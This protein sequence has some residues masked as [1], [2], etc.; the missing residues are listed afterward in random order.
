MPENYPSSMKTHSSF[1]AKN[2]IKIIT[3]IR[4]TDIRLALQAFLEMLHL[5]SV[6]HFCCYKFKIFQA[7]ADD[8]I[9]DLTLNTRS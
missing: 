4:N 8:Q 2:H 5:A 9:E 3:I 6:F 7:Q 1:L